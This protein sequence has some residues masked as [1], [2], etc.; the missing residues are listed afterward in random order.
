MMTLAKSPGMFLARDM[1]RQCHKRNK[2]VFLQTLTRFFVRNGFIENIHLFACYV[3]CL[4]KDS[5]HVAAQ[6]GSTCM[7]Q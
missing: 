5:K 4:Q 7:H 6:C 3:H 2:L 1:V